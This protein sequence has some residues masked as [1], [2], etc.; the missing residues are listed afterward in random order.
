[1]WSTFAFRLTDNRR[2]SSLSTTNSVGSSRAL[3][4]NLNRLIHF[5]HIVINAWSILSLK[6]RYISFLKDEAQRTKQFRVRN[7]HSETRQDY[8]LRRACAFI[9][10]YKYIVSSPLR[11][12]NNLNHFFV[13]R[14]F[15]SLFVKGSLYFEGKKRDA[16]NSP[17]N[18]LTYSFV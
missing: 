17:C 9:K 10:I 7:G 18:F 4:S 3:E 1:M 8:D 6:F 16:I 15:R 5:S 11:S 12:L 13:G 14:R 2:D